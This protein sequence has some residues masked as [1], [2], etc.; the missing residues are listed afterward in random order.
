VH[1]AVDV[2]LLVGGPSPGV[3]RLAIEA[4]LHDVGRCHE[5]G[6]HRSREQEPLAVP[7]MPDADVPVAVDDAFLRENAIARDE[8]VDQAL[9]RRVVPA[10]LRQQCER[11]Q[12]EEVA[13]TYRH[14]MAGFRK[15]PSGA[16]SM[17]LT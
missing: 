12:R 1:L 3:D 2:S 6:G 4:E 5:L 16:R 7:R 10:S 13:A 9:R 15:V 17:A 8:I 11:A 14:K